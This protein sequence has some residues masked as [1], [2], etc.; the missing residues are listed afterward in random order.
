LPRRYAE[1]DFMDARMRSPAAVPGADGTASWGQAGVVSVELPSAVGDGSD[2]AVE[3]QERFGGNWIQ[4]T[5]LQQAPEARTELTG[6]GT[7]VL[8]SQGRLEL[9]GVLRREI[10]GL[11]WE[12]R[13]EELHERW[14]VR[15][16][17][18]GAFKS[19][20][21]WLAATE[22]R[23]ASVPWTVLL[24]GGDLVI[25]GAVEVN[26]PLLLVAG[27][28]IRITGVVS[29][30]E[31]VFKIGEGGGGTLRPNLRALDLP[32]EPL[33]TN[34]LVVPLTF[35]VLSAPIR[36]PG[37]VVSWRPA[38]V[39][40]RAGAGRYVIRYL[41]QREVGSREIEL[42]G[43]VDDP[44][45]LVEADAVIVR[46]DLTVEPGPVWDPPRI[47]RIALEWSDSEG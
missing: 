31:D 29:S 1:L 25:T 38:I 41:G 20:D 3:L 6:S 16:A 10:E 27:G 35:S 2:G 33:L 28:R 14:R 39:K 26:G 19:L 7:I 5:S 11:P 47:D 42:T 30:S 13:R 22:D 21:D 45:L 34:P 24:A 9:G 18:L 23:A 17:E 37:G 15:Y 36:P 40:G 43:P 44:T 4:A 8:R 12:L 32:L 46:I